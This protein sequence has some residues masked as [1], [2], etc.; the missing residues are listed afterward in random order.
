[1]LR[2]KIQ[3]L[4]DQCAETTIDSCYFYSSCSPSH[5]R[6]VAAVVPLAMAPRRLVGSRQTEREHS[7]DRIMSRQ[8][9]SD[10]VRRE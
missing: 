4:Q 10:R 3:V 8:D 2:N 6:I 9:F 5:L 1:M 7:I